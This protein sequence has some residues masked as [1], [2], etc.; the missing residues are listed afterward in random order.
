MSNKLNA[1][2]Q[3]KIF[4]IRIPFSEFKTVNDVTDITNI[5]IHR[6]SLNMMSCSEK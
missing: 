3:K 6:P 5:S 2:S 4:S 1:N